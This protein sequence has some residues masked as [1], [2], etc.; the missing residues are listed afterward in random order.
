[1]DQLC[2]GNHQLSIRTTTD[3]EG[4][5][6]YS[7]CLFGVTAWGETILEAVHQVIHYIY[8]SKDKTLRCS[9][10]SEVSQQLDNQPR[11]V[12][13]EP[14]YIVTIRKLNAISYT[15]TNCN[16]PGK[17]EVVELG[18]VGRCYYCETCLGTTA[19]HVKDTPD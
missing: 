18:P 14:Q 8:S 9:D 2:I 13:L 6:V 1:M 4:N 15:C 7:A 19:E 11:I 12:R 17:F 3:N 16:R 10:L 5:L